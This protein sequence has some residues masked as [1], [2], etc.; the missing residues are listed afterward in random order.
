M[1]IAKQ[2]RVPSKEKKQVKVNFLCVGSRYEE[3]ERFW[4]VE[5][6]RAMKSGDNLFQLNTNER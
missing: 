1:S 2:T 5:D 3:M 6:Y 4:K